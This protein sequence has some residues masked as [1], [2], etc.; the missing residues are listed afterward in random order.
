[1]KQRAINLA[2]R[3]T[4]RLMRSQAGVIK[5]TDRRTSILSLSLVTNALKKDC[6][7]GLVD[8]EQVVR[9]RSKIRRSITCLGY[10][11]TPLVSVIWHG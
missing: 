4:V 8:L 7:S 6:N 11:P 5:Q 10:L 2:A 9:L 3:L 1:M